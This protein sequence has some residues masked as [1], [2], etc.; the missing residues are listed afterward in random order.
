M[1]TDFAPHA[2]TSNVLPIP[3][4]ASQSSSFEA[5]YAYQAFDTNDG[6]FW[7]GTGGG[8]DWIQLSLGVGK[9]IL[10][11]YSLKCN[12]SGLST[13][14]PKAWTMLGSN[15]G[16]DWDTLDTVADQTGWT[17]L[18]VRQFTCDTQ[19]TAY[20]W[21][22]LNISAN[23]GDATYTEIVEVTEMSGTLEEVDFAP[24]NMSANNLPSPYVASS[25][26]AYFEP[27][28]AFNG[29]LAAYWLGN[30]AGVDWLQLDIGSGNSKILGKYTIY[31]NQVPEAA[32][33]PKVWTMLGSNNGSDWDT[34]DTVTGQTAWAS[35][36]A[37]E[38]TCDTKTTAY[39]YFRLNVTENNG[40]ATYTQVAELYL[41]EY[42]S[43]PKVFSY[44]CF[45]GA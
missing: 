17:N 7:I 43:V 25:S 32:R 8:T 45:L 13:R 30:N 15:N 2:M 31:V 21:F 1:A 39:R 18:E 37:R 12:R 20:R 11:T 27:Y 10:E 42:E 29:T 14:A 4:V 34:L 16:T 24:H 41:N 5:Y 44:G 26:T 36:E 23:N 19:T 22:R 35:G 6:T 38:F 40:D 33:A 9:A 28:T 3:Y